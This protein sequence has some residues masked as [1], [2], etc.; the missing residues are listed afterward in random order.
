[1]ATRIQTLTALSF[2]AFSLQLSCSSPSETPPASE[3]ELT[4]AERQEI[5]AIIQEVAERS[6]GRL[7]ECYSAVELRDYYASE[8]ECRAVTAFEIEHESFSGDFLTPQ[9]ARAQKAYMECD[10]ALECGDYNTR[11]YCESEEEAIVRH[12]FPNDEYYPDDNNQDP[13]P[14]ELHP[15]YS[16]IVEVSAMR[17]A[18]IL[19]CTPDVF[20]DLYFDESDCIETVTQNALY[21]LSD[22]T[23]PA[24]EVVTVA[25]AEAERDFQTCVTGLACDEQDYWWD[26]ECAPLIDVANEHCAEYY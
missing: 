16:I 21:F 4:D 22:S 5:Q 17:C 25:C 14:D 13:T 23:D 9:C 6:C 12:C 11:A 15:G 20:E 8:E 19:A 2:L 18:N 10:V 26:T 24:K 3:D 1:M 7:Y